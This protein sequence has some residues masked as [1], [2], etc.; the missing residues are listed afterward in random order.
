MSQIF[1]QSANTIARLT[2][3]GAV[4]AIPLFIALWALSL[5]SQASSGVGIVVEQPIAFSHLIHAG[6]LGLD[7]R[8]C[9]TSVE[10]S[11]FAGMPSTQQCM[12][13]HS[14]VAQG[15]PDIQSL[16]ASLNSGVP[17]HWQRVYNLPDYVYFDHAVHTSGGIACETCHGRVDQMSVVYKATPLT[18]D[19]CLNCHRN[20]AP[21]VHSFNAVFAM[22]QQSSVDD[23]KAQRIYTTIQTQHLTDCDV[24]HR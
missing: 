8:Y 4:C 18:M 19:W 16:V 21:Y 17:I 22:E 13:C 15:L 2:L 12:T 3:I 9:H 14:Q 7:C 5:Q 24:C 20:P 6:T 11:S 10:T 23:Q 1:P